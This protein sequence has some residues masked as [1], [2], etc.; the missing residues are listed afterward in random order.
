MRIKFDKN[1]LV[2]KKK[3]KNNYASK[4]INIYIVYDLDSGPKILPRN[5]TIKI[6]CLVRML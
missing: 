3:Q 1:P 6:A 5:F 4:I 2:P